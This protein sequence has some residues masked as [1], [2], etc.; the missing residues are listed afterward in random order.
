MQNEHAHTVSALPE[1]VSAP[2]S[3]DAITLIFQLKRLQL[4]SGLA[5]SVARWAMR[6]VSLQVRERF[7]SELYNDYR[8]ELTAAGRKEAIA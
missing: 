5:K 8:Q 1:L 6:Q 2:P 7:I 4:S 3:K